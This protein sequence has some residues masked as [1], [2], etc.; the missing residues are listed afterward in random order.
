MSLKPNRVQISFRIQV[1]TPHLLTCP[2][3]H[4]TPMIIHTSHY[5]KTIMLTLKS[6]TILPHFSVTNDI[7]KQELETTKLKHTWKWRN[8]WISML[9]HYTFQTLENQ[10]VLRTL[11]TIWMPEDN[12]H[13]SSNKTTNYKSLHYY[14]IV[15][16]NPFII[17]QKP[18]PSFLKR[19]YTL[20]PYR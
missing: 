20:R 7:Y 10:G 18:S 14:K 5:T 1:C 19:G 11:Q 15:C 3:L 2:K 12:I 4:L 13:I 17:V 16:P 8:D 6:S 9:V